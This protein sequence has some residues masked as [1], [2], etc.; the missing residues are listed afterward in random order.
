MPI[1]KQIL[2]LNQVPNFK[3]L[4]ILMFFENNNGINENCTTLT[5]ISIKREKRSTL[6]LLA[7]IFLTP[8]IHVEGDDMSLFK[9]NM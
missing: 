9:H 4:N 1:P 2:V 3:I 8:A 7:V 6:A 5:M